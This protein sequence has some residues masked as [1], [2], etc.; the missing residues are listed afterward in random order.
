MDRYV[1]I[2]IVIIK[3]RFFSIIMEIFH[4][5][6]F[7][8]INIMQK[9]E[10]ALQIG[11]KWSVTDTP[12]ILFSRLP[13]WYL[14]IL[15]RQ[16]LNRS[17]L[18]SYIIVAKKRKVNDGWFNSARLPFP[19]PR[20]LESKSSSHKWCSGAS[21]LIRSAQLYNEFSHALQTFPFLFFSCRARSRSLIYAAI[22]MLLS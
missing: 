12:I 4:L 10:R 6:K 8:P 15:I 18:Y 14:Y 20:V 2:T 3:V 21:R 11:G 19:S 13:L 16:A 1:Y 5:D 7:R 22:V 9:I 17:L